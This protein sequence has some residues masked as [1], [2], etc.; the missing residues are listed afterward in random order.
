MS[1]SNSFQSR[2]E[3]K[4]TQHLAGQN[5]GYLLGAGAS[6]LDGKGYPLAGQLWTLIKDKVTAKERGEIQ[7]KL[8]SGAD[9]IEESL[10]LNTP[11]L[12]FARPRAR[13]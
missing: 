5:V 4:V 7:V 13:S 11:K 8:D 1:A 10:D 6:Y 12:N 9:G 2:L 3:A